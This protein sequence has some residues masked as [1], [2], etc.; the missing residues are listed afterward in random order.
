MASIVAVPAFVVVGLVELVEDSR[1]GSDAV[2]ELEVEVAFDF[3]I[4][5]GIVVD[6]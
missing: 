1:T 3:G 6:E 5:V 2:L 4:L